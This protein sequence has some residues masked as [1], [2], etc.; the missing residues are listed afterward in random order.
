MN[1]KYNK[2]LAT[3]L[4]A[5]LACSGAFA[6]QTLGPFKWGADL[7]LRQKWIDN[8]VLNA[9]SPTADRTLQRYRARLL[10]SYAPTEQIEASA[11][12]MREGRH[13][14]DPP[15]SAWPL[16][17][18]EDWYSGGLLFDQ[19]AVN[20]K[21]VA[22]VPLALKLGCQDIMLGHGWLVL[23]GTPLDGSRTIYFDAARA[24]YRLD[25][26]KSTLDLIYIDQSADTGRFPQSLNGEVEDQTEQN[27]TSVI[28]Y[29]RNQS[30]LPGDL[31]AYL[32]I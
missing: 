26:F 24:T 7:R 3:G 9:D 21:Q 6:D 2:I 28:L 22:G 31:D 1:A 32:I 19:L 12:L 15:R 14:Q 23:D 29:G 30:L 25:T 27:E 13:Y 18:F 20:L 11:R 4:S 8:V 10:G 17:G 5:A 16:P